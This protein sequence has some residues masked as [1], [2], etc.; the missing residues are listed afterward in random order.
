MILITLK[1]CK[2]D[3]KNTMFE[4]FWSNLLQTTEYTLAHQQ[5]MDTSQWSSVYKK[6]TVVFHVHH[7]KKMQN[8]NTAQEMQLEQ[9]NFC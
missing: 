9:T 5:H 6:N 1:V 2:W 8:P 3:L 7:K 4:T